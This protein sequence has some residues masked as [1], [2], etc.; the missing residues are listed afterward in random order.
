MPRQAT[1]PTVSRDSPYSTDGARS[2]VQK[3]CDRFSVM[4]AVLAKNAAMKMP[5]ACL[6]IGRNTERRYI[7]REEQQGWLIHGLR[8]LYRHMQAGDGWPGEPLKCG[9]NG[10]PLVHDILSHLGSL[11]QPQSGGTILQESDQA[12]VRHESLQDQN[13][14]QRQRPNS[15]NSRSQ[16]FTSS[17]APPIVPSNILSPTGDETQDIEA[18]NTPSSIL[19]QDDGSDATSLD[20]SSQLYPSINLDEYMPDPASHAGLLYNDVQT[21]SPMLQ[22]PTESEPVDLN[23][24]LFTGIGNGIDDWEI[25]FNLSAKGQ[26]SAEGYLTPFNDS[27]PLPFEYAA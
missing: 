16:E 8:E 11:S 2:R 24:D 6:V 25:F 22:Y 21:S 26:S 19:I 5:I 23:F 1:K 15:S 27:Q 3:A 7:R 14:R 9:A 17:P 18:E 13:N 10:Q 12:F 4:D 20:I